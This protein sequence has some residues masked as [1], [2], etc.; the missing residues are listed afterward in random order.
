MGINLKEAARAEARKGYQAAH[1][2]PGSRDSKSIIQIIEYDI[3]QAR[4]GIYARDYNKSIENMSE[5]LKKQ[6]IDSE[7]IKKYVTNET[8][9][10]ADWVNCFDH[11]AYSEYVDK[12]LDKLAKKYGLPDT[13]AEKDLKKWKKDLKDSIE[14]MKKDVDKL[15]DDL[16]KYHQD[17]IDLYLKNNYNRG[18]KDY[19]KD[20]NGDV[21]KA[22]EKFN[23]QFKCRSKR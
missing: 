7:T 3:N 12:R 6:G 23:K 21:D 19:V 16:R 8:H 4:N 20:A 18:I 13:I 2:I 14:S 5:F 17:G 15:T 9:H 11:T 22:K 10:G 1:L